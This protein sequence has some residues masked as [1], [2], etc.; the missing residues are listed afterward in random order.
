VL[1]NGYDAST[2]SS[3]L[4]PFTL[5]VRNIYPGIGSYETAVSDTLIVVNR[6]MSRFGAGWSLAGIEELRF[7]QPGNKVLWIGG[8]GSA[9]V[10]RNVNATTW[11]AAAG[12]YRDTLVRFDSASTSWYRRRLRNGVQ[13]TF[14]I[15]GR[16]VRTTNR[17]RQYTRF[18]WRPNC[19]GQCIPILDSIAVPPHPTDSTNMAGTVYRFTYTS[20]DTTLDRITDP[21]GRILDVA[22]AARRL[23][24]IIDPDTTAFHTDFT[25][26]PDARILTRTNR[27]SFTTSYR[28]GNGPRVDTVK[29]PLDIPGGDTA[30]TVIAA[31]DEKGLAV[32]QTGQTAVDTSIALTLIDGPRLLPVLDVAEFSVDRWGAPV[33]TVGPMGDTT[34]IVRGDTVVPS[35]V[36]KVTYHN[37]RVVTMAWN[38]RGNLVETRDSTSGEDSLPKAITRWT[39]GA[40]TTPDSPDTIVDPVGL[41]TRF[42]YD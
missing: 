31:W 34:R 1:G 19:T 26:A 38:Q 24:Q 6:R 36:T 11:R 21:A 16:H 41:R 30:A 4:Y 5:L 42:I 22:V 17:A 25:Y 12:A 28:Y 13:V 15:H 2:D 18:Y 35:L 23:T 39:Y 40:A 14:D 37:Q 3:G 20:N 27:R 32:G 10:Y 7:N 8:D 9:K 29:V 33:R